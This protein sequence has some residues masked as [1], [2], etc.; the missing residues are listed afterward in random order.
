[1]RVAHIHGMKK[2]SPT[3]FSITETGWRHLTGWEQAAEVREGKLGLRHSAASEAPTKQIT[4]FQKLL[5]GIL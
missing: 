1:M 2:A 5:E 3:A 4:Q